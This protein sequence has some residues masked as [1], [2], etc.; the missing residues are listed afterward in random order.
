MTMNTTA[1]L[2]LDLVEEM[3]RRIDMSYG[4]GYAAKHPD[5]VTASIK[6]STSMSKLPSAVRRVLPQVV[7]AVLELKTA[8]DNTMT[9]K[10]RIEWHEFLSYIYQ[11]DMKVSFTSDRRGLKITS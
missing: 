11:H 2:D 8:V 1:P 10:Q 5:L 4:E 3:R 9:P 7:E 6:F